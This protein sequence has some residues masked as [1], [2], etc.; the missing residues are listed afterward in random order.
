MWQLET[1]LQQQVA[2][3]NLEKDL[4]IS[5]AGKS[6][7]QTWRPPLIPLKPSGAHL[8]HRS[9][10][11]G[12]KE[13]SRK[14][15]GNGKPGRRK[16]ATDGVCVCVSADAEQDGGFEPGPGPGRPALRLH[17]GRVPAARLPGWADAF[18]AVGENELTCVRQEEGR[19]GWG[20]CEAE[21]A[22]MFQ[23]KRIKRLEGAASACS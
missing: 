14:T 9:R 5:S 19:R 20:G 8:Q 13:G 17:R 10:A 3:Q 23:Q 15:Q 16:G 22:A 1:S 4:M 6:Q 7:S 11:T 2:R 12:R 18:G 21:M